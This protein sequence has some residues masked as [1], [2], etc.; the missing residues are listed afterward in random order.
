MGQVGHTI[1]TG[2][3]MKNKVTVEELIKWTYGVQRADAG[4]TDDVEGS[5]RATTSTFRVCRIL[6]LRAV[7]DYFGADKGA[8][9][10][11]AE[12]VDQVVRQLSHFQIGALINYGHG[13]VA[14]NWMPAARPQL[15]PVRDHRGRPVV[16]YR[17]EINRRRPYACLVKSLLS[18][19]NIDFARRMYGDFWAGLSAVHD[20]FAKNPGALRSF[21]V[22]GIDHSRAPWTEDVNYVSLDGLTCGIKFDMLSEA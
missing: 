18:Q 4:S 21:V 13:G 7:V 2:E 15:G 8:L 12:A 6:E 10:P 1:N 14:P 3:D 9:H 16:L 11:D 17:D 20:H 5:Q 19:E 22:S